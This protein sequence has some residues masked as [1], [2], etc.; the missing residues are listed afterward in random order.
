MKRLLRSHIVTIGLAI[1]SMLFGAGNLIYPLV[2]GMQSGNLTALGMASFMVT[3]VLLPLIGLVAMILFDGN[4]DL[5]FGRL[6]SVAGKVMIF[7]CMILLGPGLVIP[8]IVTLSH[9]MLTPFLPGSLIS[10]INPLSSFMF[11][12]LFLSVTFLC[13]YKQNS[14]VSILGNIIS[15]TLLISLIIII[16][17]GVF[18]AGTTEINHESWSAIVSRNLLLGYETLDLLGAI[19]FSAIVIKLLKRGMGDSFETNKKE[20]VMIGLKAGALGVSL[21]GII[22]CG[23]AFLGAY[24]GAGLHD[25]A[26]L[27]FREIALRV[28]G[29]SGALIIGV[30]V[31]MAC[32]STAIALSAVV[33][34]YLYTHFLKQY[35]SYSL[36][37][38]IV[39]ASC[40]PLSI[41][42][43]ASVLK[44]TGGPLVYVGYP[45]LI[46]LTV[47]NILHKLW[48]IQVV[49]IPV[50]A[51]LIIA[52][53]S[54][55]AW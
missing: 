3:A 12:L 47:M 9:V 38:V 52:L 55:C 17:K 23:M 24:F 40:I 53:I 1:F 36:T 20:R 44:I 29:H 49:K 26:G 31:L 28:M 39:L 2:V 45:V 7:I 27:L 18:N 33:T 10:S 42:G 11:A 50:L 15:P 54:Y 21:L 48:G 32:L 34:D 4:Y 16:M 5:F 46:A 25:N 30:S 22:Y 19:F 6:G 41:F 37:L 51:T 14:I 43:L 35:C 13:T 8:R